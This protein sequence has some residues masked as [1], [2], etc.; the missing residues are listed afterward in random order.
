MK[1]LSAFL[2]VFLLMTAAHA[3]N[4]S[5][6]MIR[7]R[8]IY[9]PDGSH[10]ESV[11]NPETQELTETTYDTRN[12]V[13]SR[14]LYLLNEKGQVTLGSIYDGAGNLVARAQSYF[15]EF[16]RMKESRL[17]NLQGE[18]FQQTIHEYGADGKAKKPKVI[19][20]NVKTPTMRP[21]VVDFTGTTPPPDA[22]TPTSGAQTPAASPPAAD[23]KPKK[24]FFR[25]LFD[26]KE[27]K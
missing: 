12:V 2:G 4:P 3:D 24:S 20:Y 21:A 11:K 9:H 17:V 27:K 14:H 1:L 26:K 22:G 10:T 6:R 19:N 13:I 5:T 25:R 16:G 18:C 15:D 23:D 7:A 8:S